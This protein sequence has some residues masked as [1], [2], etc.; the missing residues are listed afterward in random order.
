MKIDNNKSLNQYLTKLQ[1]QL[2]SVRFSPVFT[3]TEREQMISI[4][5]NLIAIVEQKIEQRTQSQLDWL[6]SKL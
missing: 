1:K 3:D 5:N 4:Y 2:Y 6:S